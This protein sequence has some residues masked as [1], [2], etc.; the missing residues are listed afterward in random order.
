MAT[1]SMYDEIYAWNRTNLLNYFE[2]C[3]EVPLKELR[4]RDPKNIYKNFSSGTLRDVAGLDLKVD[5]PAKAYLLVSFKP[6][7]TPKNIVDII[8]KTLVL[9]EQ[10]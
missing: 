10:N 3:L 4:R 5:L 7:P 6:E 2:I 8:L 9:E 1:I